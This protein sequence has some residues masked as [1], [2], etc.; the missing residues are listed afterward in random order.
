MSEE[1]GDWGE[2]SILSKRIL[3]EMCVCVCMKFL[4]LTNSF[5]FCREKCRVELVKIEVCVCVCVSSTLPSHH[6]RFGTFSI[7][8]ASDRVIIERDFDRGIYVTVRCARRGRIRDNP[9]T[10][11]VCVCFCV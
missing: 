9:I 2:F 4:F 1:R 3:Y 6:P 10:C 11:N 5:I 7:R 8:R